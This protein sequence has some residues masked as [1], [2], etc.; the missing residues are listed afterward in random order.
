MLE[1]I[2]S[3]CKQAKQLSSEYFHR[4]PHKNDKGFKFACKQCRREEP[5]RRTP[6]QRHKTYIKGKDKRRAWFIKKHYSVTIEEYQTMLSKQGGLCAI[7]Y[8]SGPKG[9]VIDHDHKTKSARG[10]LCHRCNITLGRFQDNP[11]LFQ[12]AIDYLN[13]FQAQT[14]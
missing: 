11:Q 6:E 7:C 2:C 13:L 14:L 10:L 1:R 12:N 4:S 9:L 8:K 3:K 5:D